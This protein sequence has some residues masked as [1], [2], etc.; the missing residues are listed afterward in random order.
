M[1]VAALVT[2]RRLDGPG[3]QE[4]SYLGTYIICP[5]LGKVSGTTLPKHVQSDNDEK[6]FV[7]RL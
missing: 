2:S 4:E 1:S 5:K 3:D 6:L 7:W